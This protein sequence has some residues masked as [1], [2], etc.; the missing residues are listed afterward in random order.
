LEAVVRAVDLAHI[1]GI[2][3]VLNPTPAVA[4]PLST[5][6]RVSVLTPNAREL[7]VLTGAQTE[8]LDQAAAAARQ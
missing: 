1:R 8:T 4:L 6:S 7:G 5:R 2:P 3:V